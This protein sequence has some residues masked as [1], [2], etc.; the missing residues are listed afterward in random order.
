M[1]GP[2]G[3]VIKGDPSSDTTRGSLSANAQ[4][5][6]RKVKA[7]PASGRSVPDFH[8][9]YGSC[10]QVMSRSTSMISDRSSQ[11]GLYSGKSQLIEISVA[12]YEANHHDLLLRAKFAPISTPPYSPRRC[13]T[14]TRL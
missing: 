1:P 9:R 4:L 14:K 3:N 10:S 11:L 2:H 7:K 13:P 12:I 5:L 8:L 6:L